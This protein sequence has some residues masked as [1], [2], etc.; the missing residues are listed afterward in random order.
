MN[1]TW[2]DEHRDLIIETQSDI[3]ALYEQQMEKVRLESYKDNLDALL[4]NIPAGIAVFSER[5]SGV[6]LDYTNAGFYKLHH[7]SKE[8]WD[9]QGDNPVS[10][11]READRGIFES[12]FEKVKAGEK[13]TEAPHTG[14][15]EEDG[16][17]T[18]QQPVSPR[19]IR[20]DFPVLFQCD[21]RG[22]DEQKDAERRD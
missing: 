20:T 8:F 17:C 11:I 6:R 19:L 18:G 10:W 22:M 21:F 1:Y 16:G 13:E 7:G 2:L 12:E 14:L 15:A 4:G 3:T 5:G 9:S